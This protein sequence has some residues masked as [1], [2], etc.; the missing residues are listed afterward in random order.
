MPSCSS[1][2]TGELVDAVTWPLQDSVQSIINSA[3]LNQ[4][5]YQNT[6][7]ANAISIALNGQQANPKMLFNLAKEH[8]NAGKTQLAIEII[9]DLQ[10]QNPQL[11]AINQRTK[12]L[13]EFLAICYLRM[14]EQQNC[15]DNHTD[16]SCIVPISGTG[17]HL[18][19]DGSTL[20]MQKYASILEKFPQDYQSLWLYNIAAMT[21][22]KSDEIPARFKVEIAKKGDYQFK[23]I[24]SKIRVDHYG[25]SGSTI[26]ED[27]NND[28]YLDIL[29][30]SWNLNGD[31]VLYQN[32]GPSGFKNLTEE[33]NLSLV[34]GGLNIKQADFNNDGWMD[35]LIIRGAWRPSS[36]WG[37]L[38]NSL[39]KNNGDGTFTDV[40][41]QSRMYST[42]PSQSAEWFD[43]NNDGW[44][45]LFIANESQY[46]DRE[47]FPCELFNN[48]GDGTFTNVAKELGVDVV[49]YFKGCSIGDVN[50]DNLMDIY[51]SNLQ[52]NNV[53][54]MNNG[55]TEGQW[56]FTDIAQSAGV[57]KPEAGFPCWFADYNN[58]GY[59]DIFNFSYP[60]VC[61]FNL[62]GE[63]LKDLLGIPSDV[64]RSAVYFNN[65]DKTFENRVESV[66]PNKILG[67]MGCN[68]GDINNDGLIDLYLGN[69][70][71]DYRSVTPNQLLV[72]GPTDIYQ[73]M[74]YD[75]GLGHIQKGH[76]ISIADL[77]NDGDQDIYANMGGAFEG[78]AF[79][80]ALF[81]NPSDNFSFL[82]LRLK[83]D[84]SNINAI[85]AKVKLTLSGTSG[86][87]VLFKTLNSGSSFG[88]NPLMVQ[89]NFEEDYIIQDLSINWPNGQNKFVSY[90]ALDKNKAYKIPEKDS[91]VISIIDM[92]SF[93]W[94]EN[95][96]DR[97]HHHN[98]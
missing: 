96:V 7:R 68:Y 94:K 77:D 89:L 17:I 79:H 66:F 47:S 38:P 15:Q 83:G 4:S 13:H 8:L 24:A 95:L 44:L 1:N 91:D 58:D 45:D 34:K 65:G 70:A 63:F 50:N 23:N 78:D 48:N 75:Y 37:I 81:E 59:D 25:L 56:S 90:G 93:K 98:H 46:P 3:D 10:K 5:I 11:A 28:G 36:N 86:T 31:I 33:A 72:S 49:G 20:A 43:Y 55:E 82:K 51:I 69:G 87:K 74:S 97:S 14:A 42:R 18:R 16:E 84:V 53:L 57:T 76:G 39:M 60:T 61:F 41:L 19:E 6:L 26:I 21:L 71:P 67:T 85:G 80:N 2:E 52:G 22:N 40:T 27:F 62:S 73:N 29:S 12:F 32:Q 92:P 35:F 64:E 30:S 54:L 9:N 88:A